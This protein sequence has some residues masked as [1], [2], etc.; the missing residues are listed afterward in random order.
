MH[1][2][3]DFLKIHQSDVS[4]LT[5]FGKIS[6]ISVSNKINSQYHLQTCID[7]FKMNTEELTFSTH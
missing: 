2:I 4:L 6:I 1:T 5:K 3:V 7:C